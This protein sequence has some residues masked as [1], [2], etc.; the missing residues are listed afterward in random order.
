MKKILLTL[1]T[2]FTFTSAIANIDEK[3]HV[4]VLDNTEMNTFTLQKAPLN[5]NTLDVE[6]IIVASGQSCETG[7]FNSFVNCQAG[8]FSWCFRALSQCIDTCEGAGGLYN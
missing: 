1:A 8:G 7:C 6:N 5:L 4:E 3:T 2:V